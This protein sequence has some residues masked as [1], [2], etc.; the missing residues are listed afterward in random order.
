VAG[1]LLILTG[2][3]VLVLTTS[4]PVPAQG[5]K[6]KSETKVKAAASATKPDADGNQVVTVTLDIEKGWHLYANP[7]GNEDLDGAKTIVTVTSKVKPQSVKVE[8]PPGTVHV[9]KVIG[10][11]KVYEDRVAI[12]A[13]VQ[14]AAGD[15]GPLL[16]TVKMNAC[17][18]SKCLPPGEVKLTVP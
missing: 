2:A 6:G 4:P 9:D 7:V 10:N 11:Y 5:G 13:L 18:A 12:R 16:V 14:R 8:Y 17:D 1:A 3:V 15:T